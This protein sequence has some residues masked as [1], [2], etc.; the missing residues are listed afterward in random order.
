MQPSLL[1]G[2]IAIIQC[3]G[4]S[5]GQTTSLDNCTSLD[6]SSSAM[7]D[8]LAQYFDST[9]LPRTSK[10]IL[11][12]SIDLLPQSWSTCL[13]SLDPS[14]LASAI[15]TAFATEPT[16]LAAAPILLPLILGTNDQDN[17]KY[18]ATTVN[19]TLSTM[20]DESKHLD[21]HHKDK[22]FM[23]SNFT[24]ESVTQLCSPL[25][26]SILPCIQTGILGPIMKQINATT[27]C[28]TMVNEFTLQF[29]QTIES[30]SSQLLKLASDVI[31]STQTPGFN[32]T[33][34]QT[35]GYSWVKSYS[36]DMA[37]QRNRSALFDR[38]MTTLQVPNEQSCDA[39]KGNSF[40]TTTGANT[41]LFSKPIVP[42]S[43][44][45]TVDNLLG[46]IRSFP[47][48]SN[49]SWGSLRVL[50]LF[51]DGKCVNGSTMTQTIGRDADLLLSE[52]DFSKTQVDDMCFHLANG[53]LQTC[54]FE[55][56]V[57]SAWPSTNLT[58]P[59]VPQSVQSPA[60]LATTSFLLLSSLAIALLL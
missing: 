2:A 17:S 15:T 20:N 7:R 38:V 55:D 46:W 49:A 24:D 13:G 48:M 40:T 26:S 21:H 32:G 47:V 22:M 5:H 41:T 25:T 56:S 11:E 60:D 4:I 19:D 58:P 50:D 51:E 12:K 3:I 1:L 31:C 42:G 44:A 10:F 33:A 53:G 57:I 59:V 30:F 27:C 29:G 9:S 43:C 8:T 52:L 35:C 54:A 23:W 37:S 39:A 28:S 45:K 34:N 18:N 16:C 14:A 36:Q 6:S